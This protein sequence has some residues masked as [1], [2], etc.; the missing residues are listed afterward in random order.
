MKRY[1]KYVVTG[2]QWIPEIPQHWSLG[3]V[4]YF[5]KMTT[6]FTPATKNSNYYDAEKGYDW[7]TIGDLKGRVIYNST[8]KISSLAINDYSPTP[9]PK[10]SL[11][12]SFKLSVGLVGFAGKELYTNEAIASFLEDSKTCL[13]YLYY[14]APFFIE[15]N[16]NTNIYGAHIMNQELIKN[17]LIAFPPIDEQK[18]IA[19][20]L[21]EQCAKIDKVIAAQEKRV[22][23]LRE[24]KQTIITRAVTRGINPDVKL[25]DS[26]VEWIGP[27]PEHWE[28]MKIR[29]AYPNLGSGTTPDTNNPLYYVDDGYNW[30]QTGDLT[31]GIITSTSKYLSRIAVSEKKMRFYPI[32]SIVIAMYG[33]TIGKVGLLQ[34]E[35]ST[36]QAC[37]VLPPQKNIDN[38][39]MLFVLKSSRDTLISKS[40]GGGQPNISQ[41]IIQDHRIPFP[42]LDEQQA[43]ACY[44]ES[45]CE[46]IN[47]FISTAVRQIQLL[48]EY[49]QSLITEVVTGKRKVC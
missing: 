36:N 26:G 39:F 16:A 30:L 24:L 2:V 19:N 42:A 13:P 44:L 31:D 41:A 35:T 49:K 6:G 17:A 37:C 4:K 33:A 21:D 32:G 5:Y 20:Y 18:A 14:A 38:R 15:F 34:I 48:K 1:N 12:Y 29:W 47:S 3:K 23:L 10:G 25:K 8:N 46:R 43:I 7:V 11:M 9:T 27:I 28:I 40:I 22:E 45:K